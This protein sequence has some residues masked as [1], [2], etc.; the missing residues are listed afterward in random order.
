MMLK[1]TGVKQ[2]S[3]K[4]TAK[5]KTLLFSLKSI[6]KIQK[7]NILARMVVMG[8][9]TQL[10][11]MHLKSLQYHSMLSSE[12]QPIL[13][14]KMKLDKAHIFNHLTRINKKLSIKWLKM[15]PKY[16]KFL[17]P[18]TKEIDQKELTKSL[19][20]LMVM[21]KVSQK[22]LILGKYPLMIQL[23]NII[24]IINANQ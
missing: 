21:V 15:V 6:Q 24:I 1:K 20:K 19:I 4:K 11:L 18:P 2:I 9:Q 5:D 23:D 16:P 12:A 3:I 7:R 17:S 13:Q 14:E 8:S 22:R 10:I